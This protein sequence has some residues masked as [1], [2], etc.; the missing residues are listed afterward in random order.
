MATVLEE[1]KLNSNQTPLNN[2]LSVTSCSCVWVVGYI[3]EHKR[4]EK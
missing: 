3:T 4:G 1:G 2:W